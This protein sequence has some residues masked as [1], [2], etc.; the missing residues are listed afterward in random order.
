[1][2]Y[3]NYEGWPKS[4]PGR[5]GRG[6]IY[7]KPLLIYISGGEVMNVNDIT[8]IISSLGFPIVCCGALFYTNI[9]QNTAW[10]ETI[11]KITD[12]LNNN[13]QALTKLS[14]RLGGNENDV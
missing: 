10:Q 7:H 14:E 5:S 11:S 8:T 13:T 3:I 4:A 12:A 2:C 1:M 9:K 6:V